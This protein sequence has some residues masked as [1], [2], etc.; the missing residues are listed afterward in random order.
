M[1]LIDEIEAADHCMDPHGA[2]IEALCILDTSYWKRIK[3]ALETAAAMEIALN[4]RNLLELNEQ[5]N[6]FVAAFESEGVIDRDQ[7]TPATP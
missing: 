6:K 7:P 5:A 2:E 3:V 4:E 1:N